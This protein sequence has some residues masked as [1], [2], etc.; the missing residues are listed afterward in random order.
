MKIAVL[1]SGVVGQTLSSKFSQLGHR[2]QMATRDPEATSRRTE[3]NPQSGVS[4]SAWHARH[5][6]VGL[7]SLSGLSPDF[8]LLI[9]AT[10]GLYSLELLKTV[11]QEALSNKILMDVSN[12]LD[13]SKGWPPSLAVCNTDSLGEQIQREFE[14]AKVVK[15]LNTLNYQVMV[16]PE[17][18]PGKHNLFL[19]GNDADAK[20]T[21]GALLQ[22]MGWPAERILDLGGIETARG[23]EMMMPMWLNLMGVY[24]S[25]VMNFEIRK[26]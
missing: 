18:V 8:E 4:F 6:E 1:G 16:A 7:V 2:V 5:P 24:G 14:Q 25:P 15:T 23:T 26:P 10:G 17:L 20:T 11:G 22:E 13:F 21:V 19:S 9:N 3:P 12:P